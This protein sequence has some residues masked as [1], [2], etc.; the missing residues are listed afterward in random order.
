MHSIKIHDEHYQI[1]KSIA[2]NEKRK[3]VIVLGIAIENYAKSKKISLQ[4][5]KG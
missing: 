1:I 4:K 2:I 5:K 3:F